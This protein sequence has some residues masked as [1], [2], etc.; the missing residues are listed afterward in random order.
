MNAELDDLVMRAIVFVDRNGKV[1][2]K[3]STQVNNGLRMSYTLDNLE[4]WFNVYQHSQGN[5]S[6]KLTIHQDGKLVFEADGKF[7][8]KV[9]DA[10]TT[11]DEPS[12]WKEIVQKAV[13][14]RR[15]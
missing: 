1:L 2:D 13:P 15:R 9:F 10:Q 12:S 11:V 8:G 14:S 4:F 5:G 6:S 7:M 3:F